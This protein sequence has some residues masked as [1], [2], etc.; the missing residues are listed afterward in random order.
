MKVIKPSY[1][2]KLPFY[3]EFLRCNAGGALVQAFE[4]WLQAG[5]AG[6]RGFY[7]Q[8]WDRAFRSLPAYH[9][10]FS[11]EA[12]PDLLLGIITPS[13]D[14]TRRNYPFTIFVKLTQFHAAGLPFR[15]APLRCE[16]LLAGM[17]LLQ[18]AIRQ[19]N[20]PRELQGHFE[21][22]EWQP[23]ADP[24]TTARRYRN[25]IEQTTLDNFWINLWGDADDPR[26]YLVFHN[27][28]N[29]I[30]PFRHEQNARLSMGLKFP[31]SNKREQNLLEICFWLD[32]AERFRGRNLSAP[33]MFWDED[34][35]TRSP[36]LLL[37]FQP[38]PPGSF[39]FLAA[40]A[41]EHE[42]LCVL[43]RDGSAHL[44][45][46]PQ[47]LRAVLDSPQM[48]LSELLEAVSSL[49]GQYPD[50]PG[51]RFRMVPADKNQKS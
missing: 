29:I 25:F 38:P 37:F 12:S 40:P 28:S 32:V 46:V 42:R 7:R 50:S 43:D 36:G 8:H 4:T 17:R 26:K 33:V 21:A 51:K 30:L 13:Q 9:F 3:E 16:G 11:S 15:E 1:L 44:D 34:Q 19:I 24:E 45:D 35:Q 39:L 41:I 14:K 23:D 10:G 6:A 47:A 5:L 20:D 2:G 27:L 22:Q 49:A 31:L 48:M 18:Q